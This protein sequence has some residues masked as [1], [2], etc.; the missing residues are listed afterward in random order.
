MARLY[1]IMRKIRLLIVDDSVIVR[2]KLSEILSQDPFLDVVGIAANGQIALSKIPYLHPDLI[3]LDLEMPEM[4]GLQTLTAIRQSY[5]NL[6]VI[7]FSAFTERG[8][9]A[10]L[11]ALSLGAQDYVT[12]PTKLGTGEA[13]SDYLKRELIPKIKVFCADILGV[14]DNT[15]I[16]RSRLPSQTATLKLAKAQVVAIGVST[17]GPN[18]LA[19]LLSRFPADF[20]L[21]IVIVQ[22]IP[23]LFSKRLA[24][25]L[26]RQCHICVAE[27][28]EGA[29]LRSGHAWITPG[30]FHGIVVR[31]GTT[32]HLSLHQAPPEHSCRPAVDVLF[33]SVAKTFPGSAIAVVLTGMG[34]DGLQG[35]HHIREAGG[36]ILVQ[37]EASSVVWGMP[38]SVA[39]AG[40]ADTILPL[41]QIAD[42]IIQLVC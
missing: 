35:C 23:P 3:I 15:P 31:R 40:L 18:A 39:Q 12:K 32:V 16:A 9:S 4:D 5:P 1:I 27:G 13:V 25:R 8:A 11:E 17:G 26:T 38:K 20:P 24:E 6:P 36:Y 42:E 22:H 10:T 33:R 7:M 28:Y 2:Q 34:Q 30:D 21:P 37:D 19:T 41:D 29:E 14:S